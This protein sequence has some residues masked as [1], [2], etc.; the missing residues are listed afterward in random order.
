MPID[1]RYDSEKEALFGT[2]KSPITFEEY[3]S[4]IEAIVRSNEFPPDI[5]TLWDLREL[6]FNEIDRS[7]EE[8]LIS[9]SEQFPER[10][11]AKVAFVVKSELGFG[12]TRMYEILAEKLGYETMVFRDYSEAENW[13][14][15]K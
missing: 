15:Q 8:S 9:I 4:T 11:P 10:G 3:R 14:I 6:E 1:F 5:R 2:M 13:L 7:Y 12:M